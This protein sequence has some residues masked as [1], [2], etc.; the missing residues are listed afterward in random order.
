MARDPAGASV[1]LLQQLIRNACVNDGMPSSGHERRS[2]DTVRAVLEG[3]GLDL[4]EYEPLPGRASVTARITGSD[5]AAPSL[6][7]MGH[8]DVVPANAEDW[9]HDPFGGELVDGEVW[10][11]GAIDMLN[12]TAT[13]AVAVRH[14]ADGGF[15]PR[16]DLVFLGVADEEALGSHGAGWLAQHAPD[17]VRTDYLITEAGGFPLPA[18]DG[19]RLPVVTGEK[20]T[21]W[22]TLTVRG[23]PGHGSQPLR[24][25]SALV[26]AAEV[27]RR[28]AEHEVP[29]EIHE[30]WRRFVE[31][32]GL[33]AEIEGP[34]LDA[35]AIGPFL[36]DLPMLGLARQAHACT[37]M[38]IAPTI[39]HAGTKVN[40]I[41]D[42][43]E[44]QV[45]IRGLPGWERPDVEAMLVEAMGDLAGD[46]EI[47]WHYADPASSSPIDT[48]LWDVLE[49]VAH[50][51]YPDA[52]CI[53][54]FTGGATDA[55]FFRRLGTVAYGFGLFS[56]RLGF[57]DYATMF[58]GI[59]ERVDVESLS[60]TTDLWDGVARSFL[61]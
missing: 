1:E 30:A 25:D 21:F 61:A 52:R 32:L 31:G 40:V 47:T 59:D 2:V 58:H 12:L 53:P 6:L 34:F 27:V 28:L 11:R 36:K 56:E 41:P 49:Q 20:G 13:M 42:R 14:L 60:L 37:H 57:E 8:L 26:K 4:E 19:L 35:D 38:T 46:V 16:G 9:R 44:L 39:L 23:T 18:A 29:A 5:P 54:F 45:D 43:A 15:R 50:R 22:C 33:P 17:H 55:R 48:P 3:P 7:L 24:T 10:G 51:R